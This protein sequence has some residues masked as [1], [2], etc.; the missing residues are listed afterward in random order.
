MDDAYDEPDVGKGPGTA[1]IA[2]I[3]GLTAAAI[4]AAVAG[5]RFVGD[6]PEPA[7]VADESAVLGDPEALVDAGKVLFERRCASCHG[8]SGS[9]DGPI[10]AGLA[11]P[12]PGDLTDDDWTHG[13]RPEQ[14]LGVIAEG[15][16]GTSMAAWGSSFSADELHALAAYTYHLAGR[17]VP[18]ALLGPAN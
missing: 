3:L 9:G 11:G 18:D 16:D 2:L 12:G 17:E 4:V 5:G 1:R 6:R 15:V 7:P 8:K 14:V 10:A 13:D